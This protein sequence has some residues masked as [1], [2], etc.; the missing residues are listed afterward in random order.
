MQIHEALFTELGPSQQRA[1]I[2][3]YIDQRC[4]SSMKWDSRAVNREQS[5]SCATKQPRTKIAPKCHLGPRRSEYDAGLRG[6]DC[7]DSHS[8]H[9]PSRALS[10]SAPL[11]TTM[12][13]S[14]FLQCS[15][16]AD[17]RCPFIS[18]GRLLSRC[19][20]SSAAQRV[21]LRFC[22]T[23]RAAKIRALSRG[24]SAALLRVA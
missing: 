14:P 7:K 16:Q 12:S 4:P 21:A 6:K 13:Q 22:A 23:T 15:R 1:T 24:R 19:L 20:S 2:L 10:E 5:C 11:R 9:L 8:P 3:S 17:E 18:S